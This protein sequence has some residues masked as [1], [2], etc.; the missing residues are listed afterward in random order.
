MAA[1]KFFV[2]VSASLS[3]AKTAP[4]IE[5]AMAAMMVRI[6]MGLLR[7]HTSA[8]RLVFVLLGFLPDVG[9]RRPRRSDHLHDA[10]LHFRRPGARLSGGLSHCRPLVV[11]D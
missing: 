3:C 2:T 1:S 8:Y 7:L 9:R 10:D 4:A 11:V 5:K 6:F